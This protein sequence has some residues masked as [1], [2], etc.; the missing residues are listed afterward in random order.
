MKSINLTPCE[1]VAKLDRF[2][3]GQ[4]E[5]KRAVAIA[6][7]NRWR[8]QQLPQEMRDDVAPKNIIMSGP[9][10]VGKTE[11]ARRLALLTN[12]PFVKVEATKFT[13]VG[14]VGRDVESMVRD[15]LEKAINMVHD[16]QE[17]LWNAKAGEATEEC[18]L[19]LLLPRPIPAPVST[20]DVSVDGEPVADE[21]ERWERNRAK[22]RK[23]LREDKLEDSEIE[24]SVVEKGGSVG[25]LT[26]MGMDQMDPGLQDMFDKM[27]PTKKNRR[28]L[29][30]K[31]ARKIIYN[32][33]IDKL[34][35]HDKVLEIAINLTEQGGIIFLDEIDKVCSGDS[36]S[37]GEVSREGVQRDLLPLV[38]GCSVNTRHGHVKTDHILFIAAGAF[39]K[40]KPSDLMPELQGRFPI[41]VKLKDLDEMQFKR[42]L[43]EPNNALTTQQ[44]ALLKAD[45][46]DLEFTDCGVSAMAAKAFEINKKQQNIGA[47]RLYAII[48]KVLE[49]ISF[50]APDKVQGKIV[51]DETFVND[52]IKGAQND[53]DLN[54]FGFASH[55]KVAD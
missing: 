49:E 38:E 25:I 29:P 21:M 33:E 26:N 53:D 51:I 54:V 48:E 35:D 44:V 55:E 20:I 19:D 39:W 30:I 32:Q 28:K 15:L 13:E 42:I 22:F 40:N 41:R 5:A 27:I 7:R 6:I 3:I 37:G 45:G 2:I 14:Y 1:I 12:A 8:R 17:V 31:E 47:R 4:D 24:I 52:K 11:I 9:T 10:G 16:D 34:I 23:K 36:I 43:V 50:D 18:L 46:I